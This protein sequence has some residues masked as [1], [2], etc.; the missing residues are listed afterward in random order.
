MT[1]TSVD[2]VTGAVGAS[3][4]VSTVQRA[5]KT[6]L[7]TAQPK[8]HRGLVATTAPALPASLGVSSIVGLN[9]MA[10][11]T[12]HQRDPARRSADRAE[13]A[14]AGVVAP[15]DRHAQRGR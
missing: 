5:L 4:S 14:R 12:P 7:A 1:V 13:G 3:A 15:G 6:T 2:R 11:T 9:T 8:G 10:L